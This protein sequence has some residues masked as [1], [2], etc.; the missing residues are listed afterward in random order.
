[1][2]HNSEILTPRKVASR[3]KANV[4]YVP[5]H[6][7]GELDLNYL[8][9]ITSKKKDGK[10]MLNLVHASNFTGIINPVGKIRDIMENNLG[11][12]GFIYLD[13]AQSAPHIK[14]DLDDLNVDFAG[15]SAHK[16]YGPMGIGALFIRKDR[17]RNVSNCISGGSAIKLVSKSFEVP[18]GLP[19]RLE[20]GTQNIE[21]AYEWKLTMDYLDEI[22]M[23][24]IRKH[25]K[26]LGK[27]F[28]GELDKI[29]N[30]EIYG[31]KEFDNRT[32]VVSF[33][34][35]RVL[36][37]RYDKVARELD[38]RK[39]SVRDGCFCCHIYT[40]KQIGLGYVHE[41]RA[42]LMKLGISDEMMKLPGAVRASFAFYNTIEDAYKAVEAIRD[43]SENLDNI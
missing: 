26:E 13:M 7:K 27:Y 22:D 8:D 43:L 41:A 31:P 15:C 10:V 2:E 40:A 23:E 38:K 11:D 4:K 33:N 20:P 37:K 24:R 35:G 21:G 6:G 42:G 18:R 3:N 30:V 39:I 5:T 28:V 32:P 9:R 14:I 19:E 1:M 12:R 36:K 16:M 34:I 25:D 17:E 29:D